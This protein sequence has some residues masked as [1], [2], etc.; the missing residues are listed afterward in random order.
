[1][2]VVHG[3]GPDHTK[4][5]Y[6]WARPIG[7]KNSKF[8]IARRYVKASQGQ[9][10]GR[11]IIACIHGPWQDMFLNDEVEIYEWN[12][13][14][15]YWFRCYYCC[16]EKQ[17]IDNVIDKYIDSLTPPIHGRILAI[18]YRYVWARPLNKTHMRHHIARFYEG[19][20]AGNAAKLK[21]TVEFLCAHYQGSWKATDCSIREWNKG[22]SAYERCE[23]CYSQESSYEESIQHAL[24]NSDLQSHKK[25]KE[26]KQKPAE[27]PP[28]ESPIE[29]NTGFS[30]DD[31]PVF[32]SI[33]RADEE[34]ILD[35]DEERVL[36]C[37]RSNVGT[38]GREN[39]A[40]PYFECIKCKRKYAMDSSYIPLDGTGIILTSYPEHTGLP[41]R[42]SDVY[43]CVCGY[44]ILTE[45]VYNS[46]GMKE[47]VFI[48]RPVVKSWLS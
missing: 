43:R 47:R 1:M 40:P 35:S 37:L 29:I 30:D 41:N 15:N 45:I 23:H 13:P 25:E 6:V 3:R 44:P 39:I 31:L 22:I 32:T 38:G 36:A 2:E 5:R 19:K 20:F 14:P 42:R 17:D 18:N 7:N 48:G 33:S 4:F 12:K 8:H 11:T 34:D 46:V 21:G 27:K 26:K 16:G 10:A 24:A 28:V 9:Y